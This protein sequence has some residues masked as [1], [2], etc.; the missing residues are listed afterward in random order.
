MSQKN[1]EDGKRDAQ[2][3]LAKDLPHDAW[4]DRLFNLD[5]E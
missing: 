5:N 2:H 1:F 4:N 3:G